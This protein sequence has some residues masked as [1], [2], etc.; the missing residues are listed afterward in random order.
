MQ[1]LFTYKNECGVGTIEA[2]PTEYES[3]TNLFE[4]TYEHEQKV[5]LLI[6]ELAETAFSEKDYSTFNFLQWYVAE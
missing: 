6:N 2:L 1:K 4:Q 5:T 3:I